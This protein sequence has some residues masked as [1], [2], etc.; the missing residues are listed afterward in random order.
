VVF[1]AL[2]HSTETTAA[3]SRIHESGAA[4]VRMWM[5]RVLTATKTRQRRAGPF[6]C[7]S[8]RR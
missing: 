1:Y 6:W 8:P 4:R 2:T 5:L 3:P 7:R